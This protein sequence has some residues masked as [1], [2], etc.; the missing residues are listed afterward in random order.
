MNKIT[1]I[2]WNFWKNYQKDNRRW[3]TMGIVTFCGLLLINVTILIVFVGNTYI[4]TNFIDNNSLKWI[5]VEKDGAP[6]PLR[7]IVR[8]SDDRVTMLPRYDTFMSGISFESYDE[9]GNIE[10]VMDVPNI[11]IPYESLDFFGIETDDISKAAWDNGEIVLMSPFYAEQNNL[12]ENQQLVVPFSKEA[13]N[14]EF[15]LSDEELAAYVERF[16]QDPIKVTVKIREITTL[17]QYQ[18]YSLF[19]LELL[20][21]QHS[22]VNSESAEVF[23][24]N[25][26]LTA[27]FYIIVHDFADVDLVANEYKMKG[28]TLEYALESFQNLS[29]VLANVQIVS[30]YFILLVVVIISITFVN[31]CSQILYNRKHEI[32]LQQALGI[33]KTS[34]IWSTLVEFLFQN[35]LVMVLVLPTI[36]A[37]WLIVQNM[38]EEAVAQI[39]GINAVLFVWGINGI[40]VISISLIGCIL[41]LV[42]T[43][44]L[45]IVKLLN[46]ID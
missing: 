43:F 12:V 34:L 29:S 23:I 20:Y 45:Q 10:A 5:E 6:V 35:A 31:N 2:L 7:Q 26:E 28:Y 30:N 1:F 14:N 13:F 19:P 16:N 11:F 36:V 18:N 37:E 32:G 21:K 22:K 38:L 41:P 4:N 46:S 40:I 25:A 42:K 17:P 15:H 44:R 24:A 33:N 27:G 39:N 3:L 9:S 8:N